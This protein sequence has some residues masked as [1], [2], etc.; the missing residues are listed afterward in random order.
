MS[1][2][3]CTQFF[4]SW[5]KG[6]LNGLVAKKVICLHRY[7]KI[8]ETRPTDLARNFTKLNLKKTDLSHSLKF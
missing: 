7:V 4:C 1:G 3:L 5:L 2:G 6:D 8:L